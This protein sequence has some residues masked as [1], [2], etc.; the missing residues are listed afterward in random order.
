[1]QYEGANNYTYG[2]AFELFNAAARLELSPGWL[3]AITVDNLFGFSTG[4]TLG[5]SVLN[6]G[7]QS[8]TSVLNPSGQVV[9]GPSINKSLQEVGFRTYRFSLQ[10]RF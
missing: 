9:Y 2:P 4:T 7:S 1:M 8:L 10:T 6:Q 5:R 3:A